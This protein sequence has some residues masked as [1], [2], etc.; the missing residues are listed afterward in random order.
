VE[1]LN[2]SGRDPLDD[3]EVP[4]YLRDGGPDQ[5]GQYNWRI[6]RSDSLDRLTPFFK[7][8]PRPFPPSYISL[9]SRYAFP[10]FEWYSMMFFANTGE[11]IEWELTK[12]VLGDKYLSP[13][14]LENG[15][16][17]FGNPCLYNYDP[18]CFDASKNNGQ[19]CRIVR[20]DH[21]AI[22]CNSEI[23]VVQEISSSFL[24]IAENYLRGLLP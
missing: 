7:K 3:V 2:A 17:Q 13:I 16:L 11:D 4:S 1:K 12:K 15:Y 19:E 6:T 14:L 9:I 20:I 5:H 18:I 10:A 23:A 21:E 24:K 8:L 22:L